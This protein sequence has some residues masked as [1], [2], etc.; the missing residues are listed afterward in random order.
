MQKEGHDIKAAV[1]SRTDEPKWA[2]IC[3]S[4]LVVSDGTTIKDCFNHHLIEISS[5]SKARHLERLHRKTGIPFEEMCFFDNEQWNIL[6]V[7]RSLPDVKCIY[8]PDG[9]TRQAWKQAKAEFGL[10]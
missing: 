10:S 3:L 1:A 8:T 5:G 6:D 4:H 7:S 2:R 9:M